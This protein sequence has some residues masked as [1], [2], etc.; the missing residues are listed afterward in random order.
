MPANLDTQIATLTASVTALTTAGD[1]AI[2]MLNGIKQM[3]ADA[4]A[5]ALAAG[6][7]AVQLQALTDLGTKLDSETSNLAAAVVA[8]TAAPAS[9]SK[10]PK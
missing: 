5:K 4:V 10:K 8:N 2:A 7:T 3:I 9:T 6:A 1:S